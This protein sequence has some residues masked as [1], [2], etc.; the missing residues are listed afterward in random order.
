MKAPRYTV[1]GQPSWRLANNAV[2]AFVTE[3]GGHLGPVTFRLG[4]RTVQPYHVAPW[5]EEGADG[6]PPVL[7]VLRGDFFCLPFGGNADPFERERH[8]PHG[9]TANATWT[10]EKLEHRAETMVL[11][12]SLETR[13]RPGH[14]VKEVALLEGH[15]ALYGRHTISGM[16]GPMSFG[17]HAMLRFPD[18]EGSGLV[19][20]SPFGFGQTSPVPVERPAQRGYSLLAPGTVFAALDAVTTITGETADLSHYPARRGFED[21]VLLASDPAASLAWT[22]VTFPAEGFVWFTLKDPRVLRQTVLW[23]SNGGRHYPPWSGRHVNVLGLEEVTSY[24]HLGL[25]ESAAANPLSERGI[26]TVEE[27]DGQPFTVACIAAVAAVPDGFDHVAAMEAHEGEDVV[28][29]TARSGAAV[30]VP[31]RHRWLGETA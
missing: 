30:T 3:T 23:M 14:V 18:Y 11:R 19:A 20:T 8:P 7:R 9:E 1:H 29:L 28:T 24:F 21:L 26:P 10:F 16:A 25:A 27:L 22:A 15:A 4:D 5:A 13:V 2:E 6:L 12:L 17:H 31:L